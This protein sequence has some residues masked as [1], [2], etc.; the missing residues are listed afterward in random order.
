MDFSVDFFR[1]EVRCGFYIP[2]AIKQAWAAELEVLD[3]IERICAKAK[4]RYFADWGTI[5]GAVRH[6]GFVPWDDDLDVCML[7]DD[8][9]RFREVADAELPDGYVIHDYERQQDHWLFLARI[10]N[11]RNICFEPDYL[12]RHHNFPYLAGIDIFV[13]DYLYDDPVKEKERDDEIMHILA[14]ADGIVD[15]SL[16]PEAVRLWLERFEKKYGFIMDKALSPRE[17]GIALYRL[18]EKQMSRVRAEETETVGQIFPM[19]LKGGVGQKKAYYDEVIRLPFENTTIP[20][21]AS[22][23]TVLKSRYGDYLRIHKVWSGHDYPFFEGQCADMQARADFELPEYRFDRRTM[24]ERESESINAAGQE[25]KGREVGTETK[26]TEKK[27]RR[28]NSKTR[29]EKVSTEQ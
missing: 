5:L 18:A 22:Y 1:D 3:V 2:T 10:V 28:R 20:V 12:N 14:V 15:G 17:K 21:P 29:T 25:K 8:Y 26:D 19:I 13:K 23:D 4:I 7:R 24:V 16:K 27:G 11:N 9:V 6:G